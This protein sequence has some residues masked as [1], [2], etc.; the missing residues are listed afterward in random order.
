MVKTSRS[1]RMRK[2]DQRADRLRSNWDAGG[3]S[4]AAAGVALGDPGLELLKFALQS[5]RPALI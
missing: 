4:W 5:G 1:H 2:V 3:L